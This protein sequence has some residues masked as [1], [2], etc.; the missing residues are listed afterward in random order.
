VGWAPVHFFA[1]EREPSLR[2]L[3]PQETMLHWHGDTFD[4]PAG[5]VLLA[6]TPVCRHQAFRLGRRQIGLQFHCELE[7]QTIGVWAREDGD[8]ARSAL[9][10]GAT[11]Q[12]IADTARLYATARPAWDRLL[13]N[14]L[15]LLLA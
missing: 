14:A 7:E 9:G 13:A 1:V 10:E 12:I 11:E 2:G 15:D 5:A 8:F 4:L 3:R 6:S